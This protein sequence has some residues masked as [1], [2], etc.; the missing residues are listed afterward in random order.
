MADEID[1]AS[2]REEIAR[3]SAMLT[4]KRPEGPAASGHCLYCNARLPQP[5]RWCDAECRNE[6]T[7]EERLRGR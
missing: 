3:Q 1:K 4:S 5:M 6:W 7:E 2:E